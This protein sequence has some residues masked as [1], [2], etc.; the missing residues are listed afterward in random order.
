[1]YGGKKMKIALIPP[2]IIRTPPK[3]YGGAEQVVADLGEPLAK[4]G[5]DVTIF[6]PKGSF[7]EGCKIVETVDAPER[8]D[9][10]WVQLEKNA[11]DIYKDKLQGFDIIHDHSWFGFPYLVK[12]DPANKDMHFCHTKHGHFDWRADQVPEQLKPI[13]LIA[14]SSFMQKEFKTQG[15]E[16]RVVYNG[17]NLDRYPYYSGERED[18]LVCIGRIAKEK[19]IHIAIQAAKETNQKLVIM[20][21]SFVN[22]RKYLDAIKSECDNSNGLCS[23]HLDVDHAEKIDAI[24]KAKACLIPSQFGEL[25]GLVAP[26]SLATGTPAIVWADGALPEIITTSAVGTVC[27]DYDAFL[28]AVQNVDAAGYVQV[29]CRQRAE[30]FSRENMAKNYLDVYQKVIGGEGW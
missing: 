17:I 13:N 4:L 14:I 29:A 28:K 19:G 9:V 24:S 7:A 12:I 6:A 27:R 21:G 8:T 3:N 11:Y 18:Y 1:V 5:H 2:Q 23:L 16:S 22:D 10:N 15:W 30:D 25:F 20:G 26:E